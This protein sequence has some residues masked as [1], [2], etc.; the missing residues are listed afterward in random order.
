MY[1]KLL[2]EL[3]AMP[4]IDAHE[5]LLSEEQRTAS[6]VDVLSLFI[7]YNRCELGTAGMCPETIC[8]LQDKNIPIEQRWNLFEPF[9]KKIEFT[10]YAKAVKIVIRELLGFDELNTSTYQDISAALKHLNKKGLY[11]KILKKHCH[12]EAVLNQ[13][14]I[15]EP[16]DPFFKNVYRFDHPGLFWN[17]TA[18]DFE[19]LEQEKGIKLNNGENLIEYIRKDFKEAIDNKGA[20]GFK[21]AGL[22]LPPLNYQKV[23]ASVK[24]IRDRGT[25][26]PD[27][28]RTVQSLITF[29]AIETSIKMDVPVAVHVGL[30]WDNWIDFYPLRPSNIR[31][32]VD[33]YRDAKFDLYH[34]GIPW[35]EE[36]MILAKIYPNVWLNLCWS[37]IISQKISTETLIKLTE[38][39]PVNKILAFGGD[40]NF[41]VENIYGHYRMA[42][43]D[44]AA[45]LT[46]RI[47]NQIMTF[48][49]AVEVAYAWLYEN[50]RNLY[51]LE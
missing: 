3:S 12:I 13:G 37:H 30:T 26:D 49:Q 17:Q 39:I 18:S 45:A 47:E 32:W 2:N 9:W 21:V 42:L 40:Y 8:R 22:D 31:S 5:H 51:S 20:V 43:E 15:A 36:I 44:I 28:V 19:K 25:P 6:E 29:A 11:D 38:L 34:L 24:K 35:Q 41:P 1:D 4:V 33:T 14:F 48:D 50:A 10:S 23:D 46:D 27:D 16:D 7:H